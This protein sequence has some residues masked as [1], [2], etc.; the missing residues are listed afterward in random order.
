MSIEIKD[1]EVERVVRE[2]AR[3]LNT[4]PEEAVRRLSEHAL[5]HGAVLSVNEAKI[6]AIIRRF[7][8]LPVADARPV[9]QIVDEINAEV[10]ER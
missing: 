6:D 1:P 9:E 2:V 3:R 5:A 10:E 8:E 7:R 4:E